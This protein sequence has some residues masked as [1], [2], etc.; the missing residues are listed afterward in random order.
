MTIL[1]WEFIEQASQTHEINKYG[2]PI[3]GP[4][5]DINLEFAE[6]VYREDPALIWIGDAK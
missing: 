3:D 2:D 1:D 4:M 6:E 5:D